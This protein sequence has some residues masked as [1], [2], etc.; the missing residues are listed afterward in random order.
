MPIMATNPCSCI[1]ERYSLLIQN[2]STDV[3]IVHDLSD[4]VMDEAGFTYPAFYMLQVISPRGDTD[5]IEVSPMNGYVLDMNNYPRGF[6]DGVY[7]FKLDNCGTVYEQKNLL[8]PKIQCC[9][10]RARVVLN[11][12]GQ[13]EVDDI[14]QDLDVAKAAARIGNYQEAEDLLKVIQR[15]VD[16]LKCDCN[17]F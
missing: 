5:T 1:R 16:N 2:V 14:L 13:A 8:T 9:I 15:K 12:K 6:S 10:D 3:T 11:K 17:C 4:W 7:T